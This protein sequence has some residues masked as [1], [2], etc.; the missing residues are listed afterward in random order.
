MIRLTIARYY[1]PSGRCIQKPYTAGENKDYEEDILA[2]YEHGEFFSGDS[3]KH[4][5]KE[6]HTKNGR[7]VYGGGGITPDIFVAEDTTNVTSYYKQAS[8]S[9]Q[10]IMFAYSY[11]DGNRQK[12]SQMQSIDEMAAYLKHQ[13][14]VDKFATY[15]DNNGLKRRNLMIQRSHK[16]LERYI[17]SRIIYNIMKEEAWIQYL[18]SEDPAITE[19]IRV[20]R[21]GRAFP[22]NDKKQ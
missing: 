1:S 3:I 19:T 10:I 11:T 22:Q 21:E 13:N 4:E 15:A 6:Y 2:R 18:N 16:L 20:M 7:P 14:I 5:G 12:L 8:I 9:G 17:T